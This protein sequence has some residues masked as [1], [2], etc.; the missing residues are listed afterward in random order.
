MNYEK[1]GKIVG[2]IEYLTFLSKPFIPGI[3]K[4]SKAELSNKLNKLKRSSKKLN[5]S[6]NENEETNVEPDQ[7]IVDHSHV[8]IDIDQHE[9][10]DNNSASK[11]QSYGAINMPFHDIDKEDKTQKWENEESSNQTHVNQSFVEEES[12]N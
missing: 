3:L 9:Q 7:S 2:N 4:P 11:L 5:A 8:K 10:D 1:I 6:T 12:E